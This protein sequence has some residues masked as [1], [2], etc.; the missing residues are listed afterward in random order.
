M[1]DWEVKGRVAVEYRRVRNFIDDLSRRILTKGT[2]FDCTVHVTA[3]HIP[4]S[5]SIE[6]ERKPVREGEVWGHTWDSGYFKLKAEVP[7]THSGKKLAAWLDFGGE[8]L[9][10]DATGAP[11]YSLSNGSAFSESYSKDRYALGTFAEGK[12][13][14]LFVEAAA[15]N[16]FGVITASS[17]FQRQAEKLHGTYEARV[18]HAALCLFDENLWHLYLDMVH[19]ITIFDLADPASVKAARLLRTL[20]QAV[21]SYH[22]DPARAGICREILGSELSKHAVPSALKTTVV[23]HSHIDTAWLW[24]LKETRR[25]VTRTYASQLD[26]IERYPGYVFGASAP[27][28]HAWVKEDFSDV[29]RRIK[30]AV[31]EGRWELQGG[32]WIEAD[33]NIP[34][35]ESL[36]RQFLHGKNFWLDEFG[37]DVKNCWIPDVFGYSASLPQIMK[38]A[39]VDFFLTQKLSWC[40]FST[41]PHT[42]FRWRG[43]DGSE[44]LTHFPPESNYNSNADP[45]ALIKAEKQFREKAYLDEFMTLMGIGD[46]GGGPK[47]EHLE[48]VLRSRDNEGLPLASFGRVDGFFERLK[49]HAAELPVW[50]GELYLEYHRG[51]YT[52]QA[53][54][55]AN[56]RKLEQEIRAVEAL[57]SA[58]PIDE[59]PREELAGVVRTLLLHQFH[60]IL[61]GSS[62]HAVYEDAELA[63]TQAFQILHDLRIKATN[64]LCR[65]EPG[66]I[67]LFNCL[68]TPWK[69][70]WSFPATLGALAVRD[71][72]GRILAS[73]LDDG[74]TTVALTL[75]PLSFTVFCF[76]SEKMLVDSHVKEARALTP[77]GTLNVN[78]TNSGA[79]TLE[80]SLV[81]YRFNG[82]GM[83]VEADDKATGKQLLKPGVAGN[84]FS[85]YEDIPHNFDAW[86]IDYYFREQLLETARGQDAPELMRG[87]VRNG[88]R[89][90]LAVGSSTITQ[91]VWLEADSP[92]LRFETVIEWHE[93][94]K[95]LKVAF[96][97]DSLATEALCEIAY[98][99]VKRPTH[100]N[101][102][103][104]FAKFEV[105]AHRWVG[106]GDETGGMAL[107][108][109]SKYGHSVRDNV[110]EL[111]L[112]RSP[113]NPDPI[114][115]QGEHRFSYVLAPYH[116]SL[117]DSPVI[118]AATALNR[119]PLVLEGRAETTRLPVQWSGEGIS[120]EVLKK[121]EKEEAWIVRLVEIRGRNSTGFLSSGLKDPKLCTTDLMEWNDGPLEDFQVSRRV[122]LNPFEILTFKVY[123]GK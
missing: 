37:V 100:A 19:L 43:I 79:L 14:E 118:A 16:L 65:P 45:E 99:H 93:E 110:L 91:D 103:A 46:G 119:L 86:D 121:A 85:Y 39:G 112:L 117:V 78:Q 25:K 98:G 55:K 63:F 50:V 15:N 88:L 89:F 96:P 18:V 64:R 104:D 35:G 17:P 47:E 116:G 114:A 66:T 7:A 83:L 32:M 9:I 48:R 92:N 20:F 120:M 75:P 26:L 71:F 53:K 44:V 77:D 31:A 109:D 74:A 122:D 105:C 108:N 23:G 29:Y 42:T 61:P 5:Q 52:T 113:L 38:K 97:L 101:T 70:A 59:Y 1:N 3:D 111:T 24:R 4:L 80:N 56:N 76:E 34:S 30:K 81:R 123:M 68:T 10:Y 41:F 6:L 57:C 87:A 8:A 21:Q 49:P 115:D 22:E 72:S 11:L 106:I 54:I 102:D 62:I 94:H 67:T 12:N 33:C 73:Q 36:V 2:P 60:D 84:V 69:G 82:D 28:H 40:K 27:Q 95:L 58:M 13:L 51:T 90:R 107:L